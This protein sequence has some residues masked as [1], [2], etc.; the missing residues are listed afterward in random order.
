MSKK[1]YEMTMLLDFYGELL[2]EKQRVCAKMY[3]D[4]DLSLGEIAEIQNI[5]R[6]GVRDLIVRAENTLADTEAKVGVVGRYRRQ[7]AVADGMSA[8][9]AELEL[10]TDGRAKELALS[11]KSGLD[12]LLR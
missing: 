7:R 8:A 12:T 2:T 5:T 1:T 3:Y 10:L 4:E 6:Q 9:L 11:L